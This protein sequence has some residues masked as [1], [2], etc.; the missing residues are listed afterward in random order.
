MEVIV[1]CCHNYG[2]GTYHAKLIKFYWGFR[3]YSGKALQLKFSRRDAETQSRC[4]K[5]HVVPCECAKGTE[6]RFQIR[7]PPLCVSAFS[8]S[9]RVRILINPS[10][11]IIV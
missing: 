2:E 1:V 4:L 5:V 11:C 7:A 3:H 8:A 6:A 10:Y 9:L